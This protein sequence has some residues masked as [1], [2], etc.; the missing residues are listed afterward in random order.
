MP[1]TLNDS[2]LRT[3]LAGLDDAIAEGND[4]SADM[5]VDLAQQIAPVDEGD[6]RGSITKR[7]GQN[8][9]SSE[10]ISDGEEAPHN[11]YVE[12]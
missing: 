10:V 7:A 12:F 4:V 3:F 6:F 8:A 9:L 2:G 5:M 11:I 1:V